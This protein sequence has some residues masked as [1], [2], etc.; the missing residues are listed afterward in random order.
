MK[1]NYFLKNSVHISGNQK[2]ICFV[3]KRFC[4][5]KL[6]MR[7]CHSSHSCR[8]RQRSISVS[9]IATINFRIGQQNIRRFQISIT[10]NKAKIKHSFTS[11]RESM[12]LSFAIDRRQCKSRFLSNN[13]VFWE[14]KPIQFDDKLSKC[15]LQKITKRQNFRNC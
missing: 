12:L 13:H 8:H 14:A 3:R 2:N 1:S 10:P 7:N 11:R 6:W 15:H 9:D 5:R 4:N